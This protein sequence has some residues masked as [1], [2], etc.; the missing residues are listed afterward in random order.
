MRGVAA[1]Y[2]ESQGFKSF[3]ALDLNF[4]IALGWAW[5]PRRASAIAAEGAGGLK[6]RKAGW[7]LRHAVNLPEKIPFGLI[8]VAP[9]LGAGE[10]DLRELIA[11]IEASGIDTLAQSLR[12]RASKLA[13]KLMDRPDKPDI[14]PKCPGRA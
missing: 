2:G 1:I 13:S 4:H 6:K 9:N 14:C 12:G 5:A 3:E 10:D 7:E 8:E 11:S